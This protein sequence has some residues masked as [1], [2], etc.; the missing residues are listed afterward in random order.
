LGGKE[1]L[2][3]AAD[4][5]LGFCFLFPKTVLS[6]HWCGAVSFYVFSMSAAQILILNVNCQKAAKP[7]CASQH[8]A[9]EE[10]SSL[11]SLTALY[12]IPH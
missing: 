8:K 6:T 10:G 12:S 7:F 11:I 4:S 9:T 1:L 5:L 2:L 3:R